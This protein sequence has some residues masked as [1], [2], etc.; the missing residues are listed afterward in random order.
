MT[1][2]KTLDAIMQ[3]D[4]SSREVLFE[5]L[6]KRLID[7]RRKM[8][9]KKGAKAMS[10]FKKGKLKMMSAEDAIATLNKN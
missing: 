4:F 7:E 10:D 8:M 3:L 1:F 6:K 9:A 2:D 5:V